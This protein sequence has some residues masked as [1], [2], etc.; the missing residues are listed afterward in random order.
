MGMNSLGKQ[1]L[2]IALTTCTNISIFIEYS[3]LD[4]IK[5][6]ITSLDVDSDTIN[7]TG[8]P[9]LTLQH[10]KQHFAF[11]TIW[12]HEKNDYA[13]FIKFILSSGCR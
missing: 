2:L 5:L 6:T 1:N 7:T 8:N 10:C 9:Q 13:N 11:F 12:S 3:C 4:W